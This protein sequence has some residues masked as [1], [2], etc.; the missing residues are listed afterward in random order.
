MIYV[1][2]QN[3]MALLTSKLRRGPNRRS[4]RIKDY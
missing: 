4:E 2:E 1:W 3:W